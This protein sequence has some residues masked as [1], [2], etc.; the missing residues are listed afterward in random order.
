MPRT[1]TYT[2]EV[3]DEY[4]DF[5]QTG[6]VDTIYIDASKNKAYRYDQSYYPI[7]SEGIDIWGAI[8]SLSKGGGGGGGGASWGSINGTLSN[9]T[10]LQT[11]LN[12]KQNT[13]VSSTNIKT[14]NGTS[15][16]GSG[17]LVV[18]GGSG[19]QGV[20]AVLPLKT[21]SAITFTTTIPTWSGTNFQANRLYLAP[22][23]PAQN[24]IS[25]AMQFFVNIAQPNSLG[26][27]LIYSDNNGEPNLKLYETPDINFS[28]T[29]M[30]TVLN[31]F[32]FSSGTRYWIAFHGGSVISG[33]INVSSA[34]M[35]PLSGS[36]ASVS[37]FTHYYVNV[38]LGSAP[39]QISSKITA[40]GN[41]PY[42]GI[43]IA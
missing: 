23:I 19:L 15:V 34:G 10:D 1:F 22:F 7:S 33:T 38:A 4:T 29:G 5:P 20:H 37:Y 16:L 35:I 43:R 25:D 30:K 41:V 2:T 17:D 11:A 3:F 13:L 12:A 32:T 39:N 31:S 24:V 36:A 42:V 18:S 26:R 9:Q 40:A 6:D 28:T 21:G 8:G 27:L 14:I